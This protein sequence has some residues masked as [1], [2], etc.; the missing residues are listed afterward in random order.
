[1]STMSRSL[2]VGARALKAALVTGAAR[3]VGFQ[4]GLAIARRLPEG[5]TVYLTVR[6]EEEIPR[7]TDEI[8]TSQGEEMANKL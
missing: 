7:L 3:D 6:H 8:K 4:T 1:M 5:S 2:H